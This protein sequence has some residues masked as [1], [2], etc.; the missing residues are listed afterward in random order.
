MKCDRKIL[1]ILF[2]GVLIQDSM[3]TL[4]YEKKSGKDIG[5]IIK[6]KNEMKLPTC[7]SGSHSC[8]TSISGEG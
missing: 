3:L 5:V 6:S 2:H 8:S 4:E 1:L 7:G